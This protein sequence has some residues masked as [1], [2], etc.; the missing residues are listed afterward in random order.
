M[1]GSNRLTTGRARSW[2]VPL[3]ERN[4]G[5]GTPPRIPLEESFDLGR[6]VQNSLRGATVEESFGLTRAVQEV[7]GGIDYARDYDG[8]FNH[9][10]LRNL[11]DTRPFQRFVQ[12][13]LNGRVTFN[14]EVGTVADAAIAGM[15]TP[16]R[17][18][19]GRVPVMPEPPV[20]VTFN[21][22]IGTVAD[23]AL[24]EGRQGIVPFPRWREVI[25]NPH[26]ERATPREHD[27]P[28]ITQPSTE[29]LSPAMTTETTPTLAEF[30]SAN[31]TARTSR[32]SQ[33]G[34]LYLGLRE[35][36]IGPICTGSERRHNTGTP[37]VERNARYLS[38][39]VSPAEVS[40]LFLNDRAIGSA[41]CTMHLRDCSLPLSERLVV[42]DYRLVANAFIDTIGGVKVQLSHL[43]CMVGDGI[44]ILGGKAWRFTSD[45]ML[46]GVIP[47]CNRVSPEDFKWL[48]DKRMD[49]SAVPPSRIEAAQ[50]EEAEVTLP[51]G[52]KIKIKA[53]KP[54][55]NLV[56]E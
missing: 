33:L 2:E 29:E 4:W 10:N 3:S 43:N 46:K 30:L 22:E 9:V 18:G 5:A 50:V 40:S 48:F 8:D 13:N 12:E 52:K 44:L 39:H 56:F 28:F 26:V 7:L 14:G 34:L 23:V 16:G 1:A 49:K 54:P 35:L 32:S 37:Q 24:T 17:L 27:I 51:N 31:A 41:Y 55:V 36:G 42:V 45:Q 38:T 15:H 25:S 6:A 53:P 19:T 20:R 21:G 47:R 11:E